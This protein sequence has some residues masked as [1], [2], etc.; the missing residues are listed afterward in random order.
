MEVRYTTH[1]QGNIPRANHQRALHAVL[2]R[3]PEIR[4]RKMGW[5][6]VRTVHRRGANLRALEGLILSA[7][8]AKCQP[9]ER[10][11]VYCDVETGMIIVAQVD[12]DYEVDFQ[13]I[14]AAFARKPTKSRPCGS[15]HGLI[16]VRS[17]RNTRP[18]LLTYSHHRDTSR[19]AA[20][21]AGSAPGGP[22]RQLRGPGGR[23]RRGN[24]EDEGKAEEGRGGNRESVLERAAPLPHEG[25]LE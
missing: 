18:R 12:W 13:G 2:A 10:N 4:D 23:H 22:R 21:S 25:P 20:G 24:P 11:V 5:L 9:V 16:S 6:T 8:A 17:V 3:D 19:V 1:I 15:K 7:D 14:K